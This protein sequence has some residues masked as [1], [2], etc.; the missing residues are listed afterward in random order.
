MS[1]EEGQPPICGSYM[2]GDMLQEVRRP[3]L[4]KQQIYL[5]SYEFKSF[6]LVQT[7]FHGY[8]VLNYL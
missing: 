2:G 8:N 4:L 5:N 3:G 1:Q 6:T 7:L